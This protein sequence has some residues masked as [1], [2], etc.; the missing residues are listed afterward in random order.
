MP[1]N[2]NYFKSS[3]CPWN[4][5]ELFKKKKK[6]DDLAEKIALCKTFNQSKNEL[7]E[8]RRNN[9]WEREEASKERE[10]QQTAW[11]GRLRTKATVTQYG[12]HTSLS[13]SPN[14]FFS[15]F[16]DYQFSSLLTQY[17]SIYLPLQ[18][19]GNS[20]PFSNRPLEDANCDKPF[21]YQEIFFLIS[22][23]LPFKVIM[24]TNWRKEL[25]ERQRDVRS[26]LSVL[27]WWSSPLHNLIH[28]YLL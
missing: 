26:S 17:T 21:L 20:R 1:G 18:H 22:F 12:A 8:N 3:I 28:T 24:T 11:L 9:H 2:V 16:E 25:R 23:P 13:R 27:P 6:E 19:A 5:S 7:V 4:Y 14:R 10:K 15:F